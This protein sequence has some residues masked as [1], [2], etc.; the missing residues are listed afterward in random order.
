MLVEVPTARW[1][2]KAAVRACYGLGKIGTRVVRLMQEGPSATGICIRADGT[3]ITATPTSEGAEM[4][5]TSLQSTGYAPVHGL[6]MYYEIHGAGQ[7]L[8]CRRLRL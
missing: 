8:E 6:D 5:N 1:V 4:A 3:L 2:S 7:P